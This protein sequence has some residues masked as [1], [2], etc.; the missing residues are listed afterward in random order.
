MRRNLG[1][2]ENLYAGRLF[3][4]GNFCQFVFLGKRFKDG[5]L[6]SSL[7]IEIPIRH[8]QQRQ[9]SEEG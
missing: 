3:G 9:L 8:T 6:Y 5:F 4:F 7:S 2:V 1:G